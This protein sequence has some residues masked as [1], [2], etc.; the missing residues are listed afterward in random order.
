MKTVLVTGGAG[1]I[2]YHLVKALVDLPGIENVHVIDNY[3][4]STTKNHV[5]GA[6]YNLIDI[7]RRNVIL[8][9]ES[10]MFQ[11]VDTIFHLAAQ[12]RIQVSIENPHYTLKTNIMGTANVLD[13]AL[14]IEAR[15]VNAGSSS[16]L[17]G[18][19]RSPYA[20]SKYAADNLCSVYKRNYNLSVTTGCFFNVYGERQIET[21]PSA[22]VIGIYEHALRNK[23]PMPV[24]SP[25]WQTRDF[26]HVSDII[27]GLIKIANYKGGTEKF[28]LGYGQEWTIEEV[29]E[30]FGGPIEFLDQRQGEY[31]TSS[32]DNNQ[33]RKELGWEPKIH[34]RK[35][36]NALVA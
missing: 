13:L 29:A 36:I 11:D 10:L 5:D 14:G 1:F 19:H 3:Y 35:Y 30:M 24:V 6:R 9:K 34:L 7:N 2:G 31:D 33:A 21:G 15:V 20:L 8:G 12:A 17:A 18:I 16:I 23:L 27:D 25:G 28:E 4:S 26:T 32:S 22:T